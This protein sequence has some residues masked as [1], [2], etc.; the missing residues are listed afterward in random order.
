[1]E[2]YKTELVQGDL[3]TIQ[4]GDI[5]PADLRILEAND[6][7]V[8]NAHLTGELE[9]LLRKAEQS[10]DNPFE[11]QNLVFGGTNCTTGNGM[12]VVFA[13]GDNTVIGRIAPLI[14]PVEKENSPLFKEIDRLITII[15]VLVIGLVVV[16]AVIGSIFGLKVLSSIDVA[17]GILVSF[18]P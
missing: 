5:V 13:T 15:S 10:H 4:A 1:M 8:V 17:V 18:L 11:T 9:P 7:R 16:L 2:I 6:L 12:G 3:C 14:E